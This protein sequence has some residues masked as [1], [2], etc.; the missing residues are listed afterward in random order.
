MSG[1]SGGINVPPDKCN[2][3]KDSS[4]S[5]TTAWAVGGQSSTENKMRSFAEIIAAE[6]HNRNILEIHLV[7]Q[8]P[9]IKP[10]SHDDLAEL[11]FD[12]LHIDYNQCLGFNYSTGRYSVREVKF[13]PGIDISTFVKN[14]L[15]FKG[16][17]VSTKKQVNNRTKVTFRN[18]PFNIP[19]EEIIE[20]CKCYGS[21]VEN[22]VNYEK[23]F[24]ARNKGMMG[25]TR[26]VEMEMKPGVYFN[27]FYWMEGPLPGDLG[28][29]VTV[30][31]N[32][33]EQ[34]CSN[35]LKTGRGGCKA[36]G[37]G[38]ACVQLNTPRAKMTD[39]MAYLKK[40]IGYESL[41]SQ[42]LRQFPSLGNGNEHQI[43]EN[44]YD[45]ENEDDLLP[46][47]PI[48]R[49]DAKI[50]ELEK[51]AADFN[52]LK[53]KMLKMKAELNIA[54]KTSNIA[55]NK[56]KFARKVTEERLK[57]CLPVPNFEDDYSKVL[58]TLMSTLVD[59]DS[60]DM[61]PD[62]DLIKPKDDFLKE[63][64]ESLSKDCD[65]EKVKER[66]AFVK[67][68][69]V[70][71]VTASPRRRRLSTSNVSVHSSKSD[72]KRKNSSEYHGGP[73]PQRGKPSLLPKLH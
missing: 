15:D 68:K 45:D 4:L 37:N 32:G 26:W 10:L 39:Y 53:E 13:K 42:Y 52:D 31:H 50:A 23:L 73:E 69:L 17:E 20:L 16:H 60:F 44:N 3:G 51:N 58:I 24:N 1:D 57:E 33:Q 47:N 6:R 55:K 30:L 19:D 46:L 35:C 29:R 12:V 41:K 8:E 28:S 63:I 38:K 11:L 18:V 2:E 25:G 71:R 72:T 67:N 54:V 56:L 7:K 40:T 65:P 5:T 59:E 34:Q 64:E 36:F 62:T 21:P 48:E 43:D 9:N 49:R 27:N 66:L 61:D 22:K 70:E 14:S